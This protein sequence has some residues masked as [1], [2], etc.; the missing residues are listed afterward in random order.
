MHF[1]GTGKKE[2]G[3]TYLLSDHE[4]EKAR[5]WLPCI[6]LPIVRT[7]ATFHLTTYKEE[8]AFANG[9]LVEEKDEV[10]GG[11]GDDGGGGGGGGEE[12]GRKTT[13]WRLDFPCPSYL[14]CVAA[15]YV[16]ISVPSLSLSSSS[17][18]SINDQSTHKPTNP[19]QTE[20][21]SSSKKKEK[22]PRHSSP[23]A[24]LPT[25]HPKE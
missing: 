8:L 25:L 14:L 1:F 15:G 11:G 12:R 16:N 20:N 19:P 22:K 24:L 18:S 21:S 2:D 17:T 3:P 4:T 6:D 23:T 13:V 7:T 5:Y 10:V 9:V